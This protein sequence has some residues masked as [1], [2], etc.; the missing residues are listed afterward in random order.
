MSTTR[1][2]LCVAEVATPSEGDTLIVAG[3]TYRIQGAPVRDRDG[4]L[5]TVQAYPV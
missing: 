3:Q 1:F 4:L 2:D 5:W